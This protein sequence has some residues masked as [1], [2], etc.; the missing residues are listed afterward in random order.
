MRL[1][2]TLDL[3]GSVAMTLRRFRSENSLDMQSTFGCI[4]ESGS[5]SRVTYLGTI[6]TL[7]P[8]R[9]LPKKVE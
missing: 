4:R 9:H 6:A 1:L 3:P 8:R 2:D 5:A 7:M